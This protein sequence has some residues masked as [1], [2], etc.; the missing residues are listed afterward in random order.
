MT[1]EPRAGNP[2]PRLTET[3][4]GM[5]NAVGL[6]NPGIDAWLAD[7]ALLADVPVPVIVNIGGS[8]AAG[9]PRGAAPRRGA[10][11]RGR[12]GRRPTSSATS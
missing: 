3:A 1:L 5:I 9:L 2:P 7:C 4:A 12:R 11:R 8:R 10:P 6:Q